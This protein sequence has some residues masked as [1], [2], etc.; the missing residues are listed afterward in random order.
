MKH[1][2]QFASTLLLIPFGYRNRY[3]GEA[4]F[5]QNS[6]LGLEIVRIILTALGDSLSVGKTLSNGTPEGVYHLSVVYDNYYAIC[7]VCT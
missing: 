5:N 6:P 7:G 1:R 2:Y 4:P 3:V